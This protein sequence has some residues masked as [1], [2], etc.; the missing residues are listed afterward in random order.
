MNYTKIKFEFFM[1]FKLLTAG[2]IFGGLTG[3]GGSDNDTGYIQLY[4][5]SA[6]SPE[7]YVTIDQYDDDDFDEKTHSGVAFSNVSARVEYDADNYDLELAWQDEY[8]DKNDLESIY[9]AQIKIKNDVVKFVVI[10][11]DIK[12]PNILSYEL[13]VRDD[14]E[15]EDDSDDE[16]FNIRFLNIH[17]SGNNIDVYMSESDETFNEAVLVAQTSYTELTPNKK[18]DQDDYIFYITTAGG[19]DVLY[20]STDISFNYPSEY[21]IV[22]RDNQGAGASQYIIDRVSTASAVEY[23][24]ATSE[25]EFRVYNAIIEHDLLPSYRSSIDLYI[26]EIDNEAEISSLSFGEMSDPIHTG[27]GDYSIS[28]TIPEND[29]VIVGSNLLSLNENSNKTLF[30][31]LVEDDVDDDG[32]GDVD[33]D[34]DGIVDEIE[35]TLKSL[36]VNNSQGK[37]IFAHKVNVINLIDH[38]DYSFVDVYFVLS[39]EIANT[40]DNVIRAPYT[41]PSTITLL[42]NT[43]SVYIIGYDGTS[44]VILDSF[45]LTLNEQSEDFFLVIEQDNLSSTGFSSS[46]ILQNTDN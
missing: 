4:N 38:D 45:Y 35:I 37:G 2:L 20:E 26:N 44:D 7:I 1:K 46:L 3:C 33:E 27:F 29:E 12:A 18:V 13:P 31:Y 14:D 11:E 41:S 10:A 40:A 34:G 16:L 22:I 42:N 6:N 21:I 39:D 23:P 30:F 32:D 25:A 15:K 36:V 43:Y 9:D 17:S 8:N 28:L 5:G 24:D 19:G